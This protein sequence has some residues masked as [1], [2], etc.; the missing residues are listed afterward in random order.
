MISS[1]RLSI[2]D[3]IV[4]SGSIFVVLVFK[5]TVINLPYHW[6]EMAYIESA[7]Q[8]TEK[9]FIYA[10][11]GHHPPQV[12]WGHPP[13]LFFFLSALYLMFGYSVWISHLLALCFAI[14]GIFYTYRLT[15]ILTDRWTGILAGLFLFMTLIY[16]AQSSMVLPGIP[17]AAVGVMCI[18]FVLQERWFAYS[19]AALLLVLLKETALAFVVPVLI[20]ILWVQMQGSPCRSCIIACIIPLMAMALFFVLQKATTGQFITNH[21][22]DSHELFS[23]N[24][25]HIGVSFIKVCGWIGGAQYRWAATGIISGAFVLRFNVFWRKEFLLF[26]LIGGCFVTVFSVIYVLPRYLMPI[27][28][29]L[30]VVA[31]CSI[32]S[33]FIR[34]RSRMLVGILILLLFVTG[35]SNS[36]V[37]RDSYSEDMQFVDVVQTQL[38]A[39][40]YIQQQFSDSQIIRKMA[41]V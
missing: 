33:L 28:P 30:F 12:F 17:V 41:Y 24:P 6:D 9:S 21:Y 4:F 1:V 37:G 32:Q 40:S 13:G 7:H 18:C 31:A 19:V 2:V 25:T 36:S 14:L 34:A 16:F 29:L 15:G 27:L 10:L 26:L 11:P 20:Y 38:E 35:F 8:L 3:L 39:A 5:A 22:F 23:L